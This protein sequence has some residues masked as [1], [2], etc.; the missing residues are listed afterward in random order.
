M[1][2]LEAKRGQIKKR[3]KI[4]TWAGRVPPFKVETI[5][6][7]EASRGQRYRR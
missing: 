6:I 7:L 1:Q 5:Q 2:I 4:E 3:K